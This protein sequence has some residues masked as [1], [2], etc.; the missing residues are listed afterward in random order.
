ME[1]RFE[2]DLQ[3]TLVK[4]GYSYD[5]TRLIILG[6]MSLIYEKSTSHKNKSMTD[7]VA[8]IDEKDKKKTLSLLP[9]K[10]L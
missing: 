5:E 3:I 2:E 7:D 10:I 4:K 1:K 6:I 9:Q 8:K